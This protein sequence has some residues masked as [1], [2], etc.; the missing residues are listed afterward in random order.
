MSLQFV[1]ATCHCNLSLQ[2]VTATCHCNLSL[3]PV[4]ATCHC[5]LSLQPVTATC[6]CKLS[7]Q[8]VATNCCC[9]LSLQFVAAICR[10]N[11]SQ[12]TVSANCHCNL[13]LQSAHPSQTQQQTSITV[14]DYNINSYLY[15]ALNCRCCL[16]TIC[17]KSFCDFISQFFITR[18]I[19]E[20]FICMMQRILHVNN[21]NKNIY[22]V[23]E[24]LRESRKNSTLRGSNKQGTECVHEH[25]QV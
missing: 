16:F 12:P 14:V 5:N 22:I 11:L 20:I 17:H 13:S 3:Q 25:T 10:C 15:Y 6:H 21:N 4:T 19:Y 1:T 24:Q 8:I 2:P 7:L 9:K 18:T 23:K